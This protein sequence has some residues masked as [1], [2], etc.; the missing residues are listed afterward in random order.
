MY[1]DGSTQMQ[2]EHSSNSLN[3]CS[4]LGR[5]LF[6]AG[7]TPSAR[8]AGTVHSATKQPGGKK[9]MAVGCGVGKTTGLVGLSAAMFP[10]SQAA[11]QWNDVPTISQQQACA[12][13]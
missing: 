11:R 10:S 4:L 6:K 7:S 13:R 3:M 12:E 1:N 2:A 9:R 5:Q 8:I